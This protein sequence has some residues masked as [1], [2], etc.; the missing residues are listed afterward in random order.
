MERNGLKFV[1]D[2]R[3]FD[4]CCITYMSDGIHNDYGGHETLEE[5]KERENNPH[6]IAV[7]ENTIRKMAH[8]HDRGLCA[9]FREITE[10][11][12]YDKLD[13]LPPVRYTKHFFFIGEPYSGNIYP[14]CFNM[15]GR[16]FTGLRS[17]RTPRKELE[18]QM[19]AHYDNIT[20]RAAIQKEK[21]FIMRAEEIGMGVLVIPYL[22]IDRNGEK[23]FIGNICFRPEDKQGME[24]VKKDMA[25]ILLSLRRHHFLYFS[26]GDRHDDLDSFLDRVAR[27][28]HTLSAKGTFFQYPTNR[29]SVSF[30]GSVKETGENFFYRIYDRELFLH[31]MC[32]LRGVKREMGK[33]ES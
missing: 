24:N 1:V 18:R 15:G 13:A 31:L 22:F 33:T 4:G 7:S 29:E 30:S 14:F 26:D 5:L 12:Y 19:A 8:I 21:S 25:R 9:P 27:E 20:F 2:S 3:Y 32:R 17:V 11:E 23:K 6:L 16:Y 28:K 10:E